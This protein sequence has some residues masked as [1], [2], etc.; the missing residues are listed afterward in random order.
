M[1]ASVR[2]LASCLVAWKEECR[3][4]ASRFIDFQDKDFGHDFGF[5]FSLYLTLD[6][7]AVH[8]EFTIFGLDGW[9]V[10]DPQS[11]FFPTVIPWHKVA[12]LMN[13][14]PLRDEL[15]ALH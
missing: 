11:P 2:G 4:L 14:G 5:V 6:G 15:L 9:C 10:L 7:L 13:P 8:Q 1:V 3:G 12:P